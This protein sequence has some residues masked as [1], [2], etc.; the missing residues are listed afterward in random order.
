MARPKKQGEERPRRKNAE[1]KEAG[2][3]LAPV[4]GNT[5][6]GQAASKP[7]DISGWKPRTA[8]GAKVKERQILTIDEIID[9]SLKIM[10]PEIVDALLATE[11]DLLMI[12]Q[13]KGKFGGGA[14]RIFRQTQKKTMEGNKPK[15]SAIAIVGDKNGHV[16]IGMGCA[17]ETV[18]AREKAVKKA[19]LN[20]FRIRRGCG[21]WQCGCGKPHSIPFSVIGRCGSVEIKFMPAPKG[22]GL[23]SAPDIAKI[24][25]FAGIKDIWAKTRGQTR[26]RVNF[27]YACEDALRK[28]VKTKVQPDQYKVVAL[29]EGSIQQE[30]AKQKPVE[31]EVIEESTSTHNP[32]INEEA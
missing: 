12:G 23:C 13:S 30:A 10:E 9:N 7:A 28:L 6:A 26:N 20:I 14:R 1:R 5:A 19:K 32:K 21:S 24:L 8:L 15:F 16:G 3:V 4:N 17:K 22:K 11:N 31:A 2:A 27:V 18:P 29:A 25:A